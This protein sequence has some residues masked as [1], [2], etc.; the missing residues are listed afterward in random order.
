MKV[1]VIVPVYNVQDYL[2]KCIE[3]IIN[4]TFEDFELIL[5]DDGSTDSSGKMCDDYALS[6]KR[7]KVIH[8]K[9]GGLSAARNAGLDIAKGDYVIFVDSDDYIHR[10]MLSVMTA[11]SI[12][13]HSDLTLCNYYFV[14]SQGKTIEHDSLIEKETLISKD[15]L[16]EL[17]SKEWLPA[18][19]PWNKL[20]RRSIFDN[21]RYPVGKRH[22]DEFI[23]HRIIEKSEKILLIPQFFYFYLQRDNSLSKGQ[24]TSEKFDRMDAFLDRIDFFTAINKKKCALFSLVNAILR[25]TADWK[26]KKDSDYKGLFEKYRKELLSRYRKGYYHIS[27]F[28]YSLVLFLFRYCFPLLR[29]LV[30]LFF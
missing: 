18:V 12:E 13:E 7:I 14:D 19:V 9:N 26:Y 8:Q 17:L 5:I 22:E 25:L 30:N 28:K 23:S 1:S 6:D 11:K 2:A 16:F 10:E 27:S 4:Q 15:S 3:S 21:L 20:Y 24:F 29:I